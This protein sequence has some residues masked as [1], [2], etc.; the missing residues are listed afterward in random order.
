M[1]R[2]TN[3]VAA[4]SIWLFIGLAFWWLASNGLI[5]LFDPQGKYGW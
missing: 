2:F 5:F 1:R 3:W 4:F